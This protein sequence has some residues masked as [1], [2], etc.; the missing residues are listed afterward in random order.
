MPIVAGKIVRFLCHWDADVSRWDF[1]GIDLRWRF[2]WL[3]GNATMKQVWI[4]GLS[5]NC[6]FSAQ[7]F[8][9]PRSPAYPIFL[10]ES[11]FPMLF[12]LNDFVILCHEFGL[13]T[14]VFFLAPSIVE[15]YF[16]Q[17]FQPLN[18]NPWKSQAEVDEGLEE[19]TASRS[20]S[21]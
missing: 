16:W 15:S 3:R 9:L 4:P 6:R 2:Q 11:F 7:H 21:L 14:L 1:F 19:S 10:R 12:C 18:L 20:V 8:Q 13:L 5:E 17:V